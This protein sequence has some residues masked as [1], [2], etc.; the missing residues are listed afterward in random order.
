MSAT[1]FEMQWKVRWIE[2]V[3]IWLDKYGK[4]LVESKR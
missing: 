1:Y 3:E 2:G 4:M